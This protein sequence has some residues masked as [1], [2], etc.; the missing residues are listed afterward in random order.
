MKTI[1]RKD[2]KGIL[3]LDTAKA[4]ILF[5][6]VTAILGFAAI[7]ALSTLNDAGILTT[8]SEEANQSTNVLQNVSTGISGF[9]SNASTWFT[10]LSVVVIILIIGVV[11]FA[12]SRFGGGERG[13]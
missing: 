2:K 12:V 3:G 4:F 10:L 1:L 9:F 13:I 6:L 5:I 7:I 8:G 11:I